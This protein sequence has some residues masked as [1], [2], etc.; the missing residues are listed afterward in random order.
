V[1]P[2]HALGKFCKDFSLR[3]QEPILEGEGDGIFF[4][5]ATKYLG[6]KFCTTTQKYIF[7]REYF[8]PIN[9]VALDRRIFLEKTQ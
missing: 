9:L 8:V 5:V 4:N 2:L 7:I 6:A 3:K 1:C